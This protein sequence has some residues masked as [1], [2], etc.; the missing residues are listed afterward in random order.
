MDADGLEFFGVI[1]LV[2]GDSDDL[3]GVRFGHDWVSVYGWIAEV[4]WGEDARASSSSS[5]AW[6]VEYKL[7][8]QLDILDEEWICK[9]GKCGD[10]LGEGDGVAVSV[11]KH[12]FAVDRPEGEV[13]VGLD[14]LAY[15]A[16]S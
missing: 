1:G 6:V 8:D 14:Q 15:R 4:D 10:E 9:S 7:L 16:H 12:K 2:A 5:V 13:L 3:V 11:F